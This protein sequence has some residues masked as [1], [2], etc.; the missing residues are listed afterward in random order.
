MRVQRVDADRIAISKLHLNGPA[1]RAGLQI[2][3]RIVAIPPYRIR[4]ADELSRYVQS[5][6]PGETI[7]LDIR[8]DNLLMQVQCQVTDVYH[9]YALMA[10]EG[11]TS[12]ASAPRHQTF[13][14]TMGT[15]EKTVIELVQQHQIA[16]DWAALSTALATETERYGGDTRL[17]DVHF[18][19]NHPLKVEQQAAALISTFAGAQSLDHLLRAAERHLDLEAV[20]LTV[21]TDGIAKTDGSFTAS[22]HLANALANSAFNELSTAQYQRL[23][24]GIPTLLDRFGQSLQ[25][26]EGETEESRAHEQTLRLAKKVKLSPLFAAARVLADLAARITLPDLHAQ[27]ATSVIDSLPPGVTGRMLYARHTDQGWIFVGDDGPNVYQ[28]QALL[29]I[30]IG[31]DDTY[32]HTGTPSD[33]QPSAR[34]Y[35]DYAGDDRHIG[36][37]YGSTGAAIGGVEVLIDVQGNDHY[38]GD[39][40]SQGAAFCGI[41]ILWD[42]AGNDV[43]TGRSAVQATAFFGAG[44]L[45]DEAG[46]DLFSASHIAQGFGGMRGLGLLADRD[47][48][49]TYVADYRAPSTYGALGQYAGWAQGIGCGFRGYGSGGIGLLVDDAGDDRYQGGEFSQ[50]IGYFFGL[51][52]LADSGGNDRYRGRR[53]AQGAAAH[54]AIGLLI[55]TIGDDSYRTKGAASQGSAWDAAIGYLEDRSGRDLYRGGDLTQGAA[56]MNGLGILIDRSGNDRYSA[57]SGQGQ[58]SSATYWGGRGATNLGV[59]MDLGANTDHFTVPNRKDRTSLKTPGIGLFLDR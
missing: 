50:G 11:K 1:R 31:G 22:L 6:S 51:G 38:S 57:Q 27:F 41:G 24:D 42:Q 8:R 13:S 16:S 26:D 39:V 35:I 48:A 28:T 15:V 32:I 14:Q 3:D 45:I 36:N 30:D 40:L 20:D 17:Q 47:G 43:Y 46:D 34:L 10:A 9:L 53:Y 49:D 25:L 52:L 29:I 5:H 54:Q 21:Q 19:L 7:T 58:G 12:V 18:A 4:S 33:T 59:L 44:L 55:D 23:R 37:G 2:G 56:A